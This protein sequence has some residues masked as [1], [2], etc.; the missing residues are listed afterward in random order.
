MAKAAWPGLLARPVPVV[1]SVGSAAPPFVESRANARAWCRYGVK[2]AGAQSRSARQSPDAGRNGV[3]IRRYGP[4]KM[5]CSGWDRRG[6]G[7]RSRT[8]ES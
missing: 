2:P 3:R 1:I 4:R 6:G 7:M 5:P 8:R